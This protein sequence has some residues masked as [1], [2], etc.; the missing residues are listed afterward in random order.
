[1]PNS[2]NIWAPIPYM[3]SSSE[4]SFSTSLLTRLE[5]IKLFI[6]DLAEAPLYVPISIT[7]FAFIKLIM[8]G[9]SPKSS[10]RS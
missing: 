5:V 6:I 9:I 10:Y 3:R 8:R 4:L 2:D 7:F 1:M